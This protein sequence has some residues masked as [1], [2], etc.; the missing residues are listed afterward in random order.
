MTD[1][2]DHVAERSGNPDQFPHLAQSG[3]E[4]DPANCS[5]EEVRYTATSVV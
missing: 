3:L 4:T 5:I 1:P 2:S